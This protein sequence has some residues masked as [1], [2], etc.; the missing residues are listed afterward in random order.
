[1][2]KK[3]AAISARKN[4]SHNILE[5]ERTDCFVNTIVGKASIAVISIIVL[6]FYIWTAGSNG[7]PLIVDVGPEYYEQIRTPC[8]FPDI[9]PHHYGFY[10][11]LADSFAA[12]RVDLL[13]DPPKELLDLPNPRDPQANERTRIL[14][15][16]LFGKRFYLYFGPVPALV[17]FLPFRWL[18]IGKISEPL[19]V[20][21]FS[22]GLFLSS[23]YILL[24][25]VRRY[26]PNANKSLVLLSILAVAFSNSIPYVLRHPTVYEV[27]IVSGAFFAMLGLALLLRSWD[28][29]KCS[30]T[31]LLLA[32]AAFGLSAGCRAI[33]LFA[34]VLLFVYW[35]LTT[36]KRP[37]SLTNS[38]L[39]GICLSAPFTV[40]VI[41]LLI[42]NYMRFGSPT[43]F[44][45]NLF[46]GPTLHHVEH[47]N[48]FANMPPSLFLGVLCPPS[49]DNIFPFLHLRPFYPFPLPPG[50]FNEEPNGGF[51][52][53]TPI[54]LYSLLMVGLWK[55]E[56]VRSGVGLVVSLIAG[57]GFLLMFIEKFMMISTTMRYQVDF[58]PTILLG[59][60]IGSIHFESTITIPY[61]KYLLRSAMLVVIIYGIVAHLAFGVTGSLDTFRRGEPKSYFAM[62]DFFRPVS[63]A[64]SHFLKSDQL[65]ILDIT[66]PA[67]NARFDD[68][69]EGPWL[70]EKGV[71]LRFY[72]PRVVGI[73]V[74]ANLIVRPDISDGVALEVQSPEGKSASSV[75]TGIGREEFTFLLKPGVNRIAF[76]AHPIAGSN[77]TSPNAAASSHTPATCFCS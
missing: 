18:G 63:L 41:Y 30:R 5:K 10:N 13:I 33:Y 43:E 21:F 52:L 55:R 6:A 53:T 26:I 51:L 46:L 25:C 64:L 59:A 71:Y 61:K 31:W 35:L 45:M 72:S 19:T 11:L 42:Y 28:G 67:G 77:K 24:T 29:V 69:K 50:F 7:V 58:A 60:L 76:F 15:V 40:A 47:M 66:T 73:N 16:S 32:S 34:C 3:K 57:L 38:F 14:D 44:G 75:R 1:M 17:L 27:A 36:F 49:L 23:L 2:K 20:A 70:G 37:R 56:W 9:S 74:T 54:T 12:G 65:R 68:G 62:E 4:I 22:Y 8:L 48:S 39:D